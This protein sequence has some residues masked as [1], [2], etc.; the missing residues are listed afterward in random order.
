M[1]AWSEPLTK[2]AISR[3]HGSIDPESTTSATPIADTTPI[4][5]L[6]S[7]TRLRSNRSRSAPPG[8]ETRMNGLPAAK[9]T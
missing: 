2:P 7:S 3:C 9:A 4:V 1:T 5:W 6:M 8:I